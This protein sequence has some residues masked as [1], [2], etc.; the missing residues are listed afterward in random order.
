MSCSLKGQEKRER[1]I[2]NF[3][4]RRLNRTE[5][6]RGG[7]GEKGARERDTPGDSKKEEDQRR[8]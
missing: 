2:Q 6:G 4:T 5:R 7:E 1:F 8:I 3:K